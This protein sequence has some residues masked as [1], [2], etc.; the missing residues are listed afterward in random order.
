MS[1]FS[2][3]SCKAKQRKRQAAFSLFSPFS[4]EKFGYIIHRTTTY[5]E[6]ISSLALLRTFCY[7]FG[8]EF[9]PPVVRVAVSTNSPV[10]IW[11]V[12][13]VDDAVWLE[14]LTARLSPLAALYPLIYI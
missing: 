5:E 1:P 11:Q 7:V 12:D 13:V 8:A 10:Q 4:V 9:F 14:H 3:F 6:K 2:P